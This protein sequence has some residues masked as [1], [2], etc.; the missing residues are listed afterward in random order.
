MKTTIDAAG[1]VVIPKAV[2]EALGLQAGQ[3]LEVEAREGRIEIEPVPTPMRLERRGRGVVAV[4]EDDVPELTA[5]EV[6]DTL[7]RTR[8]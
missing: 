5:E 7:E 4:P 8:R 3:T 1:R 2:R 6:R